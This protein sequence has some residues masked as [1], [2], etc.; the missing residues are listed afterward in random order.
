ML[1]ILLGYVHIN[2]WDN[3]NNLVGYEVNVTILAKF[4]D[5]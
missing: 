5:R 1:Y 4:V 2:Y 3:F